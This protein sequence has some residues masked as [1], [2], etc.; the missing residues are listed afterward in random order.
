MESVNLNKHCAFVISLLDNA[1]YKKMLTKLPENQRH[2]CKLVHKQQK[3]AAAHC[4]IR[5]RD[6]AE[7]QRLAELVR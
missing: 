3:S 4:K 6:K 7:E 2:A 1:T 5:S